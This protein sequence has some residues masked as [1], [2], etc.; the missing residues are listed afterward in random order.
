MI[1]TIEKRRE[2]DRKEE[3]FKAPHEQVFKGYI[4]I[5]TKFADR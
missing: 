5:I 4:R 1:K 3:D 2:K